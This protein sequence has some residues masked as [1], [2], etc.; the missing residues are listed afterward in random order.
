MYE[1]FRKIRKLDVKNIRN[2][3]RLM[4]FHELYPLFPGTAAFQCR[5]RSCLVR[6]TQSV[7]AMFVPTLC[8]RQCHH[9]LAVLR[10]TTAELWNKEYHW[11]SGISRAPNPNVGTDGVAEPPC[12]QKIRGSTCDLSG[13]TV[14]NGLSETRQGSGWLTVKVEPARGGGGPFLFYS[15]HSRSSTPGFC[16]IGTFP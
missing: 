4:N 10:A 16:W 14:G 3:F 6:D 1:V 15:I 13:A 11:L 9:E 7:R 2:R 8:M 12:E 5:R